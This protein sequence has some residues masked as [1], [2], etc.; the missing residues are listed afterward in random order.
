MERC[1]RRGLLKKNFG[2]MV[3]KY[4]SNLFSIGISHEKRIFAENL[5]V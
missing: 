1:F 5:I 2:F 4:R 3:A